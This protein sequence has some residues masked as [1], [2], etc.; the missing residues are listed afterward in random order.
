MVK[1]RKKKEKVCSIEKYHASVAN[2]RSVPR[3]YLGI[4][5]L[6]KPGGGGGIR[7]GLEEE[8]EELKSSISSTLLRYHKN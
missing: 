4:L 2:K 1:D 3:T 8:N 6:S 7:F 5:L